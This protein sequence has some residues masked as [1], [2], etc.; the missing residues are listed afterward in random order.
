MADRPAA[1]PSVGHSAPTA[2][3][4]LPLELNVKLSLMMFLQYAIWGAWLPLLLPYLGKQLHF[5]GDQIGYI[6]AVG[7]SGRSSHRFWPDNWPTAISLRRN[8]LA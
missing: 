6:F 7:G 2:A 4:P 8:F 5:T 1:S 3:A